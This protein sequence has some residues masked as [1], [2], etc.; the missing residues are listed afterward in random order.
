MNPCLGSG[1]HKSVC[2]SVGGGDCPFVLCSLALV[3]A[4]N[5]QCSHSV[6][7]RLPALRNKP[8][9]NVNLNEMGVRW[10]GPG[11]NYFIPAAVILHHG[12]PAL[13][14]LIGSMALPPV[15]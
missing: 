3:A 5:R 10:G 1:I 13:E 2:P 12:F 4:G 6:S 8:F 11:Q 14:L 15:D 7:F 9:K